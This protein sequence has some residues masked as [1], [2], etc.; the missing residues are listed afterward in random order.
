[1]NDDNEFR[2]LH[3]R[4]IQAKCAEDIF[5]PLMSISMDEQIAQ[6]SGDYRLMARLISPE[7]R[8]ET[9]EP[10]AIAHEALDILDYFRAEAERN[11]EK[12]SY[13][14]DGCGRFSGDDFSLK[15]RM[16]EYCIKKDPFAQGELSTIHGGYFLSGD[17][18]NSVIVKILMDPFDIDLMRNEARIIKTFEANQDSRLVHL[19]VLLDQ[20]KTTNNR[21]GLIFRRFNGYSIDTVLENP[22]YKNGI[23][24]KH[25][26]WMFNRL[27][28]VLGY[29]HDLGIVHCN[30]DP[31]HLIIR[32][33][34]HN[35]CLIDWSYAA[36]DPCRTGEGFRVYNEEFSAPEV[37]DKKTPLP[38]SDLYSVGKCMIKMLGG[39]IEDDT[40]PDT[41]D[42]KL[43]RFIQYFVRESPMQR[44]RDA[45]EMRQQLIKLIEE[46]WGPRKFLE[47]EM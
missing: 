23:P 36:Y 7:S 21:M 2:L 46:L 15:T 1:M 30:I 39:N 45:D 3:A 34:D 20:F 44:P 42:D 19:P 10:L 24:Q 9:P 11:I 31:S 8:L 47:F 29:V 27:L 33:Y 25:A 18:A 13:G 38:S 6:I 43:Q 37:L 35:L 16:Q 12:G 40:M 22:R 4:I 26:V 41:V 14:I 17:Y 32:P 28:R 5:G